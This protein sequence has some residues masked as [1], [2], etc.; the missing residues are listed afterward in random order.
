MVYLAITADV[1]R[2][3]PQEDLDRLAHWEQTWKMSFHPEKC[4]N[5]LLFAFLQML[6]M[7]SLHFISDV[8]DTPRY[9]AD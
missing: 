3:H 5:V 1:D 9:L 4:I 8:I 2:V 6:A 7:C